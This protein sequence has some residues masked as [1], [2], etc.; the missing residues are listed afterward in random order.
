[1]PDNRIIHRL[2]VKKSALYLPTGK[3]HSLSSIEGF[4]LEAIT[5]TE[6][7]KPPVTPN[8]GNDNVKQYALTHRVAPPDLLS[9]LT[10]LV[11]IHAPTRGATY[12]VRHTAN[13]KD[14]S[15]HAPTRGATW[16]TPLEVACCPFQSTRPRGARL[17]FYR[18]KARNIVSIHAPTRGATRALGVKSVN[19]VSIHAPTRG[20]TALSRIFLLWNMFQSTRPRGARPAATAGYNIPPRF[21]PRAHAGR[22]SD[23]PRSRRRDF[24]FNPRAHAGRDSHRIDHHFPDLC[25]NPRAHAG[26]DPMD[27]ICV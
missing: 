12:R 8:I 1:M 16:A 23:S 2:T 13:A 10:Q 22:D 18:E 19:C 11:S 9:A 27:C 24:C 7:S 20:A 6:S 17:D 14:V 4:S 21:N 25:F 3:S 26:R 5:A 15:I